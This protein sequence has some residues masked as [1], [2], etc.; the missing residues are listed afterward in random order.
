[1]LTTSSPRFKQNATEAL[2]DPGLQ[3]ALKFSKP[4]FMARRTAAVG[5]LPEF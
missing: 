1:M 3:K 5:N 4:Q 2:A